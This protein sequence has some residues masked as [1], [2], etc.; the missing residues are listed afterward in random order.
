MDLANALDLDL[1][2]ACVDNFLRVSKGDESVPLIADIYAGSRV[3]DKG[4]SK[5]IGS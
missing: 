5:R 4:V 1:C 2:V 3:N